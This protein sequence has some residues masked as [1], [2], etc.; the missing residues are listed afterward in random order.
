MKKLDNEELVIY[1]VT[2]AFWAIA[3]FIQMARDGRTG[4]SGAAG[5]AD[6]AVKD[7]GKFLAKRE[8]S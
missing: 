1:G 4:E 8:E 2:V 3:Y 5:L 6:L 7:F